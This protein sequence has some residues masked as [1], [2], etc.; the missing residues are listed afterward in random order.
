M[1]FFLRKK[2]LFAFAFLFLVTCS[3]NNSPT[4]PEPIPPAA[5]FTFTPSSG[6]AP[7]TV[8]FT[9]TSTGDIT[10]YAWDFQNNLTTESSQRNPEYTFT[11]PGT[12]SV[13]L[14]VQ[15]PGGSDTKI[16]ENSI[17][18]LA[19][20][21]PSVEDISQSTNEDVAL[22]ITLSGS[23]P[24][25]LELTYFVQ[26]E[27]ENGSVE[28]NNNILLYTPNAD[29]NGTDTVAYVA[30]N[31]YLN[32]NIGTI[33]ITVNEVDDDPNTLDVN[34]A[35]DE[36]TPISFTL[37]AN[38]VDGDSYSFGIISNP[39]NGTISL[40]G[41][42]VLY[43]PNTNW[44]GTDTFTFEAVD[45]R[46]ALNSLSVNI[47]TATITVNAINDA[48]VSEEV[49]VSVVENTAVL[50]TMNASDIEDNSLTYSITNQPSN[51]VLGGVAG[52]QVLYTPNAGYIGSDVFMYK[53]NDGT[54]D[55]NNASVN[56]TVTPANTAPV[57]QNASFEIDEDSSASI[58]LTATDVNNDNLTYILVDS[59]SNGSVSI[60]GSTA[61]YTPNVNYHGDDT[62][63]FKA[64][65]GSLD[66]NI[67]T[68]SATINP[69]NDAPTVENIT[70]SID[71]RSSSSINITLN[72]N[73]V[74]G[75]SVSF[76]ISSQPSNGALTFNDNVVEYTPT[77]DFEGTD[78]FTFIA[79]DGVLSSNIG[80][81]TINVDTEDAPTTNNVSSSTS[82]DVSVTIT[83]DGN[84]EDDDTLTYSL[85]SNP[86][87][88]TAS[89]SGATVIYQPSLN[90]NGSDSFTYNA[91]DGT[92]DSNIST[93]S[94]TVTAIN[95]VPVSESGSLTTDEDVDGSISL[96]ASDVDNDNLS[97]SIIGQPS[98]GSVSLSGNVATF[99][100]NTNYNGLDSF[101]FITTDGIG[102]SNEATISITVTAVNDAPVANDVSGSTNENRSIQLSITLDATDVDGDDLTY[103][104]VSGVS[105]GTTSISGSTLTYTPDTNWNGTDTFT[106][107]ANDGLLDSNTASG[108]ITVSEV[109]DAPTTENV[110]VT[111]NEDT[112][113]DV[114]LSATDIE[115]SSLTYSIVSNASNGSI[116]LV[117]STA[118][119]F[120]NN[121]WN[122]TD[123]FTYKANDGTDD[124]NISTATITVVP[125]NDAP[126]TQNQSV[127]TN[128]DTAVALTLSV[129]DVDNVQGMTRSIVS[130]PSN[131]SVVLSGSGNQTATYTPDV[132]WNGT[133]T[134]TW[135]AND[136]T[137]ESNTSTVTITVAAVNDTPTISDNTATLNE[138]ATVDVTLSGSDI[139]GDTLT[140]SV[141]TNPSNGTVVLSGTNNEVATYTPNTNYNGS[142]SFI[143]TANDGTVDSDSATIFLTVN[144]VNDAPT[145]EDITVSTNENRMMQLSITLDGSDVD[146][147][148]LT[149]QI[150]ESVSNGTL[151]DPSAG[152][153]VTYTPGSN[154]NG[155]DTFTYKANDGTA[156]SNTATVT[157]TVTAVNDAPIALDI[158]TSTNEDASV[159][160]TLD[161]SDVDGDSLT[162][163]VVATNNGSVTI[164]GST[165]TY[166]PDSNYNGTDTFTY[167]AND[168]TADSNTASVTITVAAV[169]DAPVAQNVSGS[170]NENR[171][172]QL[173]V[174][175][176]ATDVDGDD[177]T[178]SIVATNDGTVTVD[179]S[180]ATYT[181][182]SNFNG[183][184]TFTYKANDG[185]VDSNTATATITVSAV[186]DAPTTSAVSVTTDEDTAK[187]ITLSGSDVDSGDTL[188]Y[189]IVSDVSNGSTS[190]SG[191][192]V[193]YTPSANFNG[194]DTF[195]YKA[196]DGSLDSN[197]ATVTIT[198]A[199]VEDTPVTAD[200]AA[201]TDED[202]DVDI[203]LDGSDGDSG[204]TLTYSIVSDV[205]N[206]STS[207]SG[208]TVTY[209]PTANYNG[210]DTFTYKVNDGDEDSNTSTVTITVA[211]VNDA[212]VTINASGTIVEDN[213]QNIDLS[214]EASDIENDSLTYSIVSDVSNGSASLSGSIVTYTPTANYNGTDTFTWKVNDGTNDSNI[215]TRT[216]NVSAVNDAPVAQNVTGSTNEN[217]MMQLGITLV[218]TDVDGDDLTYSVVA[219]NDGSVT[220]SGSTATYTP[221]AN[222]NGTDTF[223][224][225]ANDGTVDS[226]TATATITV[227]SVEDTPTTADVSASTNEDTAV[228]I[229]LNGSDGDGDSLTYSVV[230]TNNGSVTIS[231]STA[232]YTPDSNYNGT[233]TFT[234]NANDGD[235]DSNTSTVTITVAAVNDAPVVSDMTVNATEDLSEIITLTA[236]DVEG[237]AVTFSIVSDVSSPGNTNPQCAEYPQSCITNDN[238]KVIFNGGQG[239]W[240]GTNSFTYKANDG[241]A[242]SNTA[243]VTIIVA[244]VDDAP[245]TT[246]SSDGEADIIT[247]ED[248]PYDIDLSNYTTDVDSNSLTYFHTGNPNNG[249][250]SISGSILTYT[251]DLNFCGSG[252][253]LTFYANDGT[254]DSN[255]SSLTI[256]PGCVD[257]APVAADGL[258]TTAEDGGGFSYSASSAGAGN[259]ITDVD[260]GDGDYAITIVSQG[261]NGTASESG[262][263]LS[264]SP[265]ANFNGTD[266]F[267][268]K[269][270]RGDGNFSNTAT[271][272]VTVTSVEDSPVTADVAASTNEDNAVDITLDGSDGD[273]GDTLTYSI[274][275][276]VSNGSTSLSGSTVTYTPTANYNGTDTFTYKVN[277]GDEDSN[278]STVTITVNS[279]EDS[280]LT[281]NV[282]ATTDEDVAVAIS[283]SGSD[284][285]SGDT[286]TYSIVSDVSNGSTSLSGS[287]V[288]YTPTANYNGTDSF[289]YKVNDGDENS[290]TSTAVIT[291]ASV[292]DIPATQDVSAS[293]DEDNAVDITLNGSDGDSGDTLTYS[294]V[295]DVSNG[296]TSLSGSTVSYTPT[297][298]YNGTDTFTYKLNDGDQDSN[299]S[300][301][302][303]TIASINDLPT[304][305][306]IATTINE[307]RYASRMTG[308]TLQGTDADGDNLTYSVV[309][310]ASNGSTSLSGSTLTY[311][312]DQD[313]NGTETIT[314]KANDGTGDSNTSTITITI[315]P[316]NDT[317]VVSGTDDTYWNFDNNSGAN[318]QV[319][320]PS[321]IHDVTGS[322]PV[323]YSIDFKINQI[324]NGAAFHFFEQGN[325]GGL[326]D[327]RVGYYDVCGSSNGN[328]NTNTND[329]KLY[330]TQQIRNNNGIGQCTI[331]GTNQSGSFGSHYYINSEVDND[332]QRHNLTTTINPSTQ[333][334]KIYWDYVQVADDSYSGTTTGSGG[335]GNRLIWANNEVDFDVYK[336]TM[337]SG[338]ELSESQIVT[339]G[340]SIDQVVSPSNQWNF[341]D[342]S[343]SL[344]IT[345]SAGSL[346]GDIASGYG[347]D[348]GET[349]TYNQ[350]TL[351]KNNTTDIDLSSYVS[352]V[353]GDNLTYSI[354]TDV[355]YGS[356]SLS[357]STVTYTPT[358][359]RS[360]ID[361]FTWKANDGVVDSTTGNVEI[362]ITNNNNAPTV[363]NAT[364][365]TDEDNAVDITLSS[366]DLDSDS[367]TYSIVSDVSNGST[368]LSGS[369]VTYTPSANYSGTDSFTYKANDGTDDSSAATVT[370]TVASVN[371]IPTTSDQSASTAQDV[372]VNIT[373]SSTDNDGDTITY[374]IVSDVS[375]GSTSLSG[376][377]VTYTPTSGFNGTDSFTFKANDG[378][379]D[380]NSSTVTITIAPPKYA[381]DLSATDAGG[382]TVPSWE[383]YNTTSDNKRQAGT[384]A[385][386]I[387][388]TE[389]PTDHQ[390]IIARADIA[391]E[392]NSTS[393]SGTRIHFT[394]EVG[395]NL[396]L[397]FG[398]KYY[399]QHGDSGFVGET[400]DNVI[401]LNTW[402]HVAFTV[403]NNGCNNGTLFG[404][405]KF[406][407]DGVEVGGTSNY[408]QTNSTFSAFSSNCGQY[409]D[410]P[411]ALVPYNTQISIGKIY[412][413]IYGGTPFGQFTG[414]LDEVV[415]YDASL[416]STEIATMYN[417]GN[418]YDQSTL[419]GRADNLMGWWNF[420]DQNLNETG[421]DTSG[422][423]HQGTEAYI[424]SSID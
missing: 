292:E 197:T 100:P 63:S 210:S 94:I 264:Y 24:Q 347:G 61:N 386:W 135:K 294:I 247:V 250:F 19:V 280:P 80:T 417:N 358:T 372:A 314:Y 259:L 410:G 38:E 9:S 364:A 193:T 85:V 361:T 115:G 396:S 102:F 192:T 93:V 174:T 387:Y 267:T 98:N 65:D 231:G 125:V 322:N 155:T 175:L 76:S 57:A 319:T 269:V 110:S 245:V 274:V 324:A 360:G 53:V 1:N 236:T 255:Q 113:V 67:A 242:D 2:L 26:T 31:Q 106:Y 194:T 353:D 326:A 239:D 119:Y 136:G 352:D 51:G 189:S 388:L 376:S 287:T 22:Q 48:P 356:T 21:A 392:V 181:P 45:D 70:S 238:S 366:S 416:S 162:Y 46:I 123:T 179:G 315:T 27:P 258:K 222:W 121:N 41:D 140:F 293:T 64:N 13:R 228:D 182:D 105:N 266:S 139:E 188:T 421:G 291:I 285:D 260:A 92:S 279:V 211:A 207:L 62:F 15:G 206:G 117:G 370:I 249:T 350:V 424:T 330:I 69:I 357:G 204:D 169:N 368:S 389:N 310:D 254:S 101:T 423:T 355:T 12:Y 333:R 143:Y 283:L 44:N 81:V 391:N 20:S 367:I 261:S 289:T 58:N 354:V 150:V 419:S 298:N 107:K 240:N 383:N 384:F 299:T 6:Y 241:T 403:Q 281:S 297:A 323:T 401:T 114:I 226:N 104:I 97:F 116:A 343:G 156:D 4:E 256:R 84:D 325:G 227:A 10:T 218:A 171:M 215:S 415:Y 212:P 173:G 122:G 56:I 83:L 220:V 263:T 148:N 73:D 409:G 232:T 235:E 128:E 305:Q 203:T 395:E 18:V 50:I 149:Y 202:T 385:A 379:A 265:N 198:V 312:A 183:T 214:S 342:S 147:D 201:S 335:F 43:T 373:L 77:T 191:S 30:T 296:S 190:L 363:S 328:Y 216:I 288:I 25:D 40:N 138:D 170:T 408:T 82:E 17:T 120:P 52:S 164:S 302:T 86:S 268:W 286:L 59:P 336:M 187:A 411:N 422:G 199:S 89:V 172:S 96:A 276:D 109:N 246:G 163:S 36:D 186:N 129:V 234:Y 141:S 390:I 230:A 95:D 144:A 145:A 329:P 133:D 304:T 273:S 167:N 341:S 74:D 271:F 406:Y 209:T 348:S 251:P 377:T 272:T 414:Y 103:S 365:S 71:T 42:N 127:S 130:N 224:Y 332:G 137:D 380:S 151:T 253:T 157:I 243:T 393:K 371:D 78:S 394:F 327:I 344:T 301:V 178:Y 374:S 153:T 112:N 407:V 257:D 177:L 39:S 72:S 28:I 278:T 300:T 29:W 16:Q 252:Q 33:T 152:D 124:S 378:T 142:D 219:T 91:N 295:S 420:D 205:S 217:R 321:M 412:R 362:T 146:G 320:V 225:K 154:F 134:F 111:T 213:T 3:D 244:A 47:G 317:P 284:G 345:D 196:N 340:S 200:V 308:I 68:I 108:T 55:S 90:F 34:V 176:V 180:T 233:D 185:T 14:G 397:Y 262:T 413:Q 11:E 313:Y 311:T 359:D 248:T 7:L 66:S 126:V 316:V 158:T 306:D 303:V 277:D 184:D 159:D 290:N 160:V 118:N 79:S 8:Q 165:A 195:T 405:K 339:N 400:V 331:D 282:T 346:D 32:S 87:N 398:S 351:N 318:E 382:F 5:N 309:S 88:G 334:I 49:S 166:T 375:N 381:L 307:N 399:S 99:S 132:N 168:G 221:D 369:T 404:N 402:H 237:D 131:G 275:S 208:S 23:D 223:T 270:D 229:T 418:W 338:T 35:T 54:D 349:Y 60:S 75:D 161:G 337:W 37:N